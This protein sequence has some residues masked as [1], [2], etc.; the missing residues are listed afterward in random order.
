M[1][2]A[3]LEEKIVK[4]VLEGRRKRAELAKR[5]VKQSKAHRRPPGPRNLS[6]FASESS[7]RS[8]E[9]QISSGLDRLDFAH[10]AAFQRSSESAGDIAL[11]KEQLDEKAMSLRNDALLESA[12]D[13]RS[14][15][16]RGISDEGPRSDEETSSANALTTE[17]MQK[18][19]LNDRMATLRRE[20]SGLEGADDSSVNAT[21]GDTPSVTVT[22]T[23]ASNESSLRKKPSV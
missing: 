14:R 6:S 3:S 1:K 23:N 20:E 13:P 10:R 12:E 2:K 19:A 8:P 4:W 16:G 22:P 9:E 17:N 18:L 15:L 11:R 5:A 21:L 7:A